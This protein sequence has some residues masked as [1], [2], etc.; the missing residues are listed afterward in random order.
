MA[1]KSDD[2]TTDWREID[3]WDGG[4]GWMA[5]PG[6]EMQRASH[7]LD[8]PEG[9][10]LVDPVD[11]DG[12]DDWLAER[13]DVRGVVV[14]LDRHKRD[15]AAVA[16]RHDVSV[17]LPTFMSDIADEFDAP[18]ELFTGEL[19]TSGYTLHKVV[20]NF[21][22]SEGALYNDANGVLLVPEALGT[23]DFFRTKG[24]RLG[25]HP[26]LRLMPPKKLA[27]LAPDRILVG[28]GAGIHDDAAAELDNAVSGSRRRT[29]SI[30]MKN[31][32]MFLPG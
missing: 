27:R 14:L 15:A 12:L 13:G 2:T 25:V 11:C 28:H 5:H 7:V 1:L 6:E 10:W 3:Q 8:G 18:V 21:A 30:Y 22:W 4:T 24:E 17:Y 26:G 23:A 20:D 9:Q 16:T 31:L 19:G 29:P 32:R